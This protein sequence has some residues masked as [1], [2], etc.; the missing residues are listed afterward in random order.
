MNLYMFLHWNTSQAYM[1]N[2]NVDTARKYAYP[3]SHLDRIAYLN[4]FQ[5]Y[6]FWTSMPSTCVGAYAWIRAWVKH[7][8]SPDEARDLVKPCA[9]SN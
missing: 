3:L 2:H 4:V 7:P 6:I 8:R 9:Y 1:S 5:I